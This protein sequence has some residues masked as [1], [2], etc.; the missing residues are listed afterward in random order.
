MKGYCT[1]RWLDHIMKMERKIKAKK[2][3][4]VAGMEVAK[5]SK[6]CL[7]G[8]KSVWKWWRW[9]FAGR[10]IGRW[11]V[12]VLNLFWISFLSFLQGDKHIQPAFLLLFFLTITLWDRLGSESPRCLSW[13]KQDLNS[14]SHFLSWC[15]N[16][17]TKLISD[18]Q[19]WGLL[20]LLCLW[21]L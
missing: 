8:K 7:E 13:L 14:V 18:L 16:Q 6:R 19:F 3:E 17:Q 11:T 21:V 1:L 4:E 12:I 9:G 2:M 15:P 5:S 20:F 10:K